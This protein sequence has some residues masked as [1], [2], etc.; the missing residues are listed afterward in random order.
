MT[1]IMCIV[2]NQW[3]SFP[4]ILFRNFTIMSTRATITVFDEQDRFHLYLH[5][6]ATPEAVEP[7]IKRAQK[8]A[9]E[10]SRFDAGE[11]TA[12]IIKIMKQRA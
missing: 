5:G 7:L 2:G 8:Y 6:D 3:D 11:F 12:A 4:A 1:A 9:W 10:L